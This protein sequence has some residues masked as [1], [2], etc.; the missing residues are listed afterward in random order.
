MLSEEKAIIAIIGRVNV[1]KST[2]FNRIVGSKVSI[3]KDDPA[4]TRDRIYAECK[5]KE[6][7]FILVDT[8]GI[9]YRKND[10]I[11]KK[12]LSQTKIAIEEANLILFLVDLKEGLQNQD[13]EIA[14]II[15]K[16]NKPVI[17]VANKGDIKEGTFKKYEF[18]ALGFGEPF[19]ISAEHNWN[20][21]SLLNKIISSL[22]KQY[23]YSEKKEEEKI[24][25]VAIVGKPNVGK[26]SLLNCILGEERI[27]TSEYPGT[28]REA[29]EVNYRNENM[30]LILVDTAGLRD[31]SIFEKDIEFYGSLRTKRA[32]NDSE[33]VLLVLDATS[34][35]SVQDKKIAHF[36]KEQKKA[37]I[38]ILNKSDLL[39]I[40]WDKDLL[41][42]QVREDLSFLK[43]IPIIM[44]SAKTGYNINKIFRKIREI[45]LQYDKQI[46]TSVLNIFIRKL[47]SSNP[48]KSWCGGILKIKYITQI[49]KKPPRFLLLVNNPKFVYKTF[50]QYL[51]N[52]FYE[53]FGFEGSPISFELK[54][55]ERR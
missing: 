44:T 36:I 39:N 45:S 16:K 40:N 31:K 11:Q 18:F 2:L 34:P 46:P 54:R 7:G 41:I 26:S 25:K 52:K 47:I 30:K 6:V 48:P 17:L 51:E 33:I 14:Q 1:G 9:E 15:R 38:L 29:I 43:N 12:V 49:G 35:V 23:I 50:L 3:V 28:T 53:E 32:I 5:W 22:P 42:K 21:E 37:Y 8:G 13:Y 24:I 10:D 4:I 20:I 27:I 19:L 55:K